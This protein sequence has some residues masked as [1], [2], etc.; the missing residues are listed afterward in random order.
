[1]PS[2]SFA[3]SPNYLPFSTLAFILSLVASGIKSQ[4]QRIKES[5]SRGNF[6]L[7]TVETEKSENF[8]LGVET[9]MFAS[10]EW[11]SAWFILISQYIIKVGWDS[12][13]TLKTMAISWGS[14]IL[15][16]LHT[17]YWREMCGCC[18]QNQWKCIFLDEYGYWLSQWHY[19]WSYF[20][21][22]ACSCG[23]QPTQ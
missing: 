13:S 16:N 7:E 5:H 15:K 10:R 22:Y 23:I 20:S 18:S 3:F 2:V 4:T 11:C 21:S 19:A 9:D 12:A 1:M 17:R 8:K 14:E 6:Q